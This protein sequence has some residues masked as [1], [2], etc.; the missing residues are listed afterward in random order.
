MQLYQ[1]LKSSS[2]ISD[3]SHLVF[4]NTCVAC[5][6]ELTKNER[7]ICSFCSMNLSPT[8]FHLYKEATSMDQLFWGRVNIKKT[9]AHLFFEK[10]KTTQHILFT[11]KYKN[12]DQIGQYFGGEIGKNLQQIPEF[13]NVD[14]YIPVPLHP[15]KEFIRGYNQSEALAKGI[16][17]QLNSQLDTNSVTRIRHSSSQTKKSRFQRWDNVDSIFKAKNTLLKYNHVVLVD[18][19][20]TTGSTI[21]SLVHAMLK[22]NPK[23]SISVV[24]LAIA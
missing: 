20:I 2:V 19:V 23:L 24:T 21:E 7:F 9:Y 14:A 18:D 15:K 11:L 13:H 22:K 8:N 17:Q 6:K 5:E 4:P 3:L 16:C 12:N 10:H 1:R